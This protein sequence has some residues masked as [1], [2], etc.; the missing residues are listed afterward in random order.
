MTRYNAEIYV[1][2]LLPRESRSIAA[3]LL[4]DPDQQAWLQAMVT[5]NILQKRTP[6]TAVRQ[7]RLLRRRLATLDAEGWKM[8]AERES[9]E[10]EKLRKKHVE[11]LAYDE[12]LRHNADKRIVLDPDDGVKVNPGKFGTLLA[13]VKAI[14]GGASDD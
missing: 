13:D 6:A 14:T 4:L 1:G 7:A 11:L 3:L 5:D 10:I 12:Q 2:S 9:E 8:I